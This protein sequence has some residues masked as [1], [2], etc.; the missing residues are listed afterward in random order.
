MA[1]N[2]C[3]ITEACENL[4]WDPCVQKNK[5]RIF[6]LTHIFLYS[7]SDFTTH[8]NSPTDPT[9]KLRSQVSGLSETHSVS[10]FPRARFLESWVS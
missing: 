2:P 8:C 9:Q 7:L 6:E 3:G 10:S 5:T 4:M 1:L